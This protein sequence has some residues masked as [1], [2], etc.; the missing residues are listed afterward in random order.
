MPAERTDAEHDLAILIDVARQ[1]GATFE[2]A[3]LLQ[4]IVTAGRAALDCDRAT[5]FLLDAAKDELHSTVATGT[6]EIRF[7]AKLGIAGEAV[8][9]RQIVH[10][11][12]AY[13]DPR[14]NREIDMKT[15]Y[16]TRNILSLPLIAPG[17]ELIGVLQAINK[18]NGSFTQNDIL[19]AGAL[20]SLTGIA[21]KRQFLLDEAA[22]KQRLERDLNIARDIQQQ[23]IPQQDPKVPGYDIS[24]WNKPAD[25]TGGDLYDFLVRDNR[26]GF[27]IADATGHGIGPALIIAQFRSLLRALSDTGTIDLLEGA[28]RINRL[29][30]DDLP[31]GRFV[32]ACFG[33]LLSETHQI[34]YVSAGHGPI[35]VYRAATG[36]TVPVDATGLPMGILEDSPQDPAVPI[37]LEPGDMFITLTDGFTEWARADGE[38]YGDDRLSAA[39]HQ[40]RHQPARELIQTLYKD[41]LAFAEGTPQL[42]DLTALLIKR[43]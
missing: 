35:V 42:D 27:M 8:Q 2:L 40:N 4:T 37:T 16:R 25:Q 38:L 32:T 18:N 23:L 33:R 17:D 39:I 7:S 28:A 14:F 29:L 41:V 26:V 11:P 20:G 9:S 34:E 5:I 31:D 21:L 30:Y 12:D 3:P 24:G 1:M 36:Q 13:A 6:G 19:V 15:G 10:V 43:T 22:E